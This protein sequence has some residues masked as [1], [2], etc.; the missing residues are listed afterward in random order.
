[1]WSRYTG[2]MFAV[3]DPRSCWTLLLTRWRHCLGACDWGQRGRGVRE[4]ACLWLD[5]TQSL[6]TATRTRKPNKSG[7]YA[8]GHRLRLG[9]HFV[10]DLKPKQSYRLADHTASAVLTC[11]PQGQCIPV[12][13]CGVCLPTLML[14]AQT[15]FLL[16]RQQVTQTNRHNWWLAH[17]SATGCT[18]YY[19]TLVIGFF[20]SRIF[21]VLYNWFIFWKNK[22]M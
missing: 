22:D 20:I 7:Q 12:A 14:I 8:P 9:W 13:C 3:K 15:F 5:T 1:M 6:M 18:L 19:V 10:C 21:D 4:P 11:W 16:Q 2:M 17:F